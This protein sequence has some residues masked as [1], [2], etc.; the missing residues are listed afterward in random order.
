MGTHEK[1]WAYLKRQLSKTL[2]PIWHMVGLNK[3]LFLLLF[4]VRTGI[5]MREDI[6]GQWKLLAS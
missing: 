1:I 3:Y 2:A 4:L 6:L 5:H